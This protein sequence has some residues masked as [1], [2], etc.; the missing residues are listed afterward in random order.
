[1]RLKHPLAALLVAA[2]ALPVV[3]PPPTFAQNRAGAQRG[4][5]ANVQRGGGGKK[6]RLPGKPQASARQSIGTPKYGG[7]NNFSGG[8][9][10]NANRPNKG[11]RPN[12]GGGNNVVAGN[13]VVVARPPAGG[14]YNNGRYYGP[15]HGGDW[16]DD[17]DD[18]FLEFV[19]KTAA[20][21]AG[22]AA[23]TAVIGSVVNKKPDDCQEQMSGGQVYLYCNGA[24]YQPVAAGGQTQYQVVAPPT[25]G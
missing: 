17:D 10:N 6:A 8:Q 13:N 7:G 3:A 16:Y 2:L 1:M 14:Y 15:P 4:G 11:N 23:V 21:T 5:G 22:V 9:H 19:G 24:W 12:R 20:V 25:G 18:D